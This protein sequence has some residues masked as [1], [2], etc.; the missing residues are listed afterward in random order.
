MDPISALILLGIVTVAASRTAGAAVTD[1]IAQ[2]KGQTPPSL[3][4]WRTNQKT[5]DARGE[6]A[7]SEPSPWRRRWNNAVEYR[8]AKAAQKHQA[9]MEHLRDHGRDNVAKRK[10]KLER[11]T[12]RRDTI[13]TR[14]AGWGET[15]WEAAKQAAESARNKHHEH[16]TEKEAWRENTRRD[17]DEP[18]VDNV[19]STPDTATGQKATVLPFHPTS[20][21]DPQQRTSPEADEAALVARWRDAVASGE[22]NPD[23]LT[24]EEWNSLPSATRDQLIAETQTAGF[25]TIEHK[26]DATKRRLDRHADEAGT[27]SLADPEHDLVLDPDRDHAERLAQIHQSSTDHSEGGADMSNA[28]TTT[29]EIT[30][31][32]TAI[33]FSEDTAK[34]TDTVAATLSDILAQLDA[35]TAGLEAEAGQYEQGKATLSGEGF[36]SKVTG[37]FDSASEALQTTAEAVRGVA[38]RLTEAS[39]QV[40]TAGGE[41]RGAAKVFGDQLAVQEQIGAA[42]QDA[43]VSKR[44]DFYAPA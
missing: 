20:D 44:T 23:V 22:S 17:T 36:G 39:E 16:K 21:D 18:A 38:E 31:L 10:N 34:Y 27:Q 32:D 30:D 14:L 24:A 4:K 41:M 8:N 33:S 40:S 28:H 13:N 42:Q 15:S 3:E 37:R 43:G 25:S 29:T 5:K 35:A 1:S 26:S 11:R 6:R 19:P 9:D 2:A 12:Q 7:T